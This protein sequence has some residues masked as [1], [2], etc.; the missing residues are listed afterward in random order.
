MLI[1]YL[2]DLDYCTNCVAVIGESYFFSPVIGES[3]YFFPVV[4]FYL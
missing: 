1:K 3:Y 2:F 4:I